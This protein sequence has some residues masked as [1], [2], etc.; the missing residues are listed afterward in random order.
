MIR[1]DATTLSE[2]APHVSGKKRED[3]KKIIDAVGEVISDTLPPY[4]IDTRLRLAHFLAQICHESDG[5]CTTVEY[6]S[7]DAYEDRKD[8]GNTQRGDG[9]RF[10]GRG[11]IQLTGRTNY[12]KYGELLGVD[13]IA[14]PDLAAEPLTALRIACEF[15]KAKNLNPLADRDDLITITERIN[16][17]QNGLESRRAYLVRAKAALARLESFSIPAADGTPPTLR[18]GSKGVAVASLQKQLRAAGYPIAIDADF[19]A[20]TELA[21][22]HFQAS[23]GLTADGIVGPQTWSA[24]PAAKDD[25][26]QDDI[27]FTP[28][29]PK[30]P[31]TAVTAKTDK[32]DKTATT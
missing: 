26:D 22:M 15:W 13:L 2:I 1:I 7:G 12:E 4:Q 23:R 10:K 30:A 28:K 8:L 16:G 29:T 9:R 17:G 14:N 19:G 5:F 3:Q 18:R 20:A 25:G 21:V 27:S 11:L 24:L 6:A 32:T 31:L